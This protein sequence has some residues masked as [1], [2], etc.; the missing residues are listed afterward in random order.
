MLQQEHSAILLTFIKLTIVIKI[1]VLSIFEWPF[2]TGFTVKAQDSLNMELTLNQEY[3]NYKRHHN[4]FGSQLLAV[5]S[6]MNAYILH[7]GDM[8][9]VF[10]NDI[11]FLR[12]LNY[13][14]T[15]V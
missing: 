7:E 1:F 15:Q 14:A 6:S 10:I 8:L 9:I 3:E 5:I 2:Y 12:F 11:R 4:L 13:H